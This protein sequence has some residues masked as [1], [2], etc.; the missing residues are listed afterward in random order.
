MGYGQKNDEYE[1][2]DP[3]ADF[4]ELLDKKY[5][6]A[7]DLGG[8]DRVA[9]IVRVTKPHAIIGAGGSTNKKSIMFIEE[10]HKGIVMNPTNMNVVAKMYGTKVRNWLGKQVTLYKSKTDFGTQKGI[11]C[12]RIRERPPVPPAQKGIRRPEAAALPPPAPK[13][14]GTRELT[15]E[16]RAA[17]ID[18][19]QE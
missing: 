18:A 7:W 5:M 11:D 19:G 17:A 13:F 3:D 1:D 6:G 10:F 15:D 2:A 8:E 4:R 14:D 16:E 12:I 9:T